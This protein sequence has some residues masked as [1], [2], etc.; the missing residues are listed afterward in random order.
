MTSITNVFSPVERVQ[1]TLG[2]DDFFESRFENDGNDNPI[3]AAWSPV[4]NANTADGVWY[5]KKIIY[6]GQA[7]VRVQL[8]DE[9]VKF[10]YV[11]DDRASLFS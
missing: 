8:P 11:W 6:D 10:S 2:A 4:P 5:V 1:N 9:G 7:I 3:Y